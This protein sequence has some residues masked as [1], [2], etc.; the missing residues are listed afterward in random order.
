MAGCSQAA[1]VWAGLRQLAVLVTVAGVSIGGMKDVA[2]Q[3]SHLA[4]AYKQNRLPKF[5][6][7]ICV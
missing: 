7:T 3:H 1:T 6:S 2:L 5:C 4:T